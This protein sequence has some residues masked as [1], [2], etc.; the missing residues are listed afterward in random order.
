MSSDVVRG[1]LESLSVVV[2][3]VPETCRTL[4]LNRRIHAS[5]LVIKVLGR[6][7]LDLFS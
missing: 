5:Y 7:V 6:S 4:K 3:F 1:R 2:C